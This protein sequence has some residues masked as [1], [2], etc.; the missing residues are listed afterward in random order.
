MAQGSEVVLHRHGAT[1]EQHVQP[2]NRADRAMKRRIIGRRCGGLSQQ[3]DRLVVVEVE[4]ELKRAR[5]H[6]GVVLG[7]GYRRHSQ[8][9]H[10]DDE[11]GAS[12]GSL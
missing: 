1:L 4:G 9:Q 2:E 5:A 12:H 11:P 3:R 8:G 7:S 10:G 6:G